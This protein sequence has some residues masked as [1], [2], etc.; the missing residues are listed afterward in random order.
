VGTAVGG[1]VGLDFGG[2]LFSLPGQKGA[3]SALHGNALAV[4]SVGRLARS[5]EIMTSGLR[6]DLLNSGTRQLRSLQGPCGNLKQTPHST[7]GLGDRECVFE[8]L[9]RD[10]AIGR[11][12][13][14]SMYTLMTSRRQAAWCGGGAGIRG[15]WQSACVASRDHGGMGGSRRGW[16]AFFD[17][18]EA[19]NVPLQP[20]RS[21]SRGDG[22]SGSF[23]DHDIA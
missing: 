9:Y 20:M 12:L 16:F 7:T 8:Q 4:K 3:E 22:A 23:G 2:V 10:S 21:I 13:G 11:V 14:S 19:K 18:D 1:A 17:F 5:V 6:W 15:P